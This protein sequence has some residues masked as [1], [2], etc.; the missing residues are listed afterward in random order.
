M[1]HNSP[2]FVA[3][4]NLVSPFTDTFTQKQTKYS[5][6]AQKIQQNQLS[7]GETRT[8][9]LSDQTSIFDRTNQL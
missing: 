6:S 5:E 7:R 1:I 4:N 2:I 8:R 3:T 9:V